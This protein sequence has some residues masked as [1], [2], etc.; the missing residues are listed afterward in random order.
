MTQVLY[1]LIIKPLSLLPLQA[2][3]LLSDFLYLIIY[4]LIPYRKK[5]VVK[6]LKNAFPEKKPKEINTLTKK[7]YKH[8][9]DLIVES[10]RVFSISKQ[11]AIERCKLTNPELL[12]DL[13]RKN[14][15]VIIICGHYNN[16]EMA[17]VAFN[18]QVPHQTVGIY[19]PLSNAFFNQK[20]LKSRG[21]FGVK[22]I[23]ARD[24][25]NYFSQNTNQL[26]ATAFGSDQSPSR[27]KT[28]FYWTKF[29]NQDTAV[30]FGAEKYAVEYNYPAVFMK[31]NKIKR[32]YYEF[33]FQL[34]EENPATAHYGAITEKHTQ[35]LEQ[36]IIAQPEFWLWTHNRWKVSKN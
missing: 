21:R 3:Y 8:F 27:N 34:V 11:E 36:Q 6:N 17:A 24:V 22:L 30:L 2:L 1:Y 35:L 25:K 20:F 9:C 12:E 15:S 26:T 29:L 18:D 19:T 5:L 33:S 16:W 28:N 10:L 32:G 31:I 7:F 4:Y 13:Y 14:K 23:V